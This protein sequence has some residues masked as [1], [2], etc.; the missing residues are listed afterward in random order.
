MTIYANPVLRLITKQEDRQIAMQLSITVFVDE[1][2]YP[3]ER[4]VDE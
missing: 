2:K 1:Q 3:L 4:V